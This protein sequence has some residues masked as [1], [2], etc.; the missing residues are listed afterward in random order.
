MRRCDLDGSRQRRLGGDDDVAIRGLIRRG[1]QIPL[2]EIE[3]HIREQR[4]ELGQNIS[5][6][7]RKVKDKLNWRMQFEQ[8]PMAMIGVALG[9]GLLLSGILGSRHRHSS[10]SQAAEEPKL[11]SKPLAP[12]ASSNARPVSLKTSM[13]SRSASLPFAIASWMVS[14]SDMQPGISGYSTR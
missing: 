11:D 8:H 1:K 9:G 3:R 6:L 13:Q 12:T 7:Q 10:I 5:E 2:A 14:P 4:H